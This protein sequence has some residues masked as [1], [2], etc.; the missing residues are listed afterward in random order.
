[1]SKIENYESQQLLKE[2][3]D[4]EY[5]FTDANGKSFPIPESGSL[6]LLAMGYQGLIAWRKE[7]S[8]SRHKG[9]GRQQTK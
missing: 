7:K 1:M 8:K 3:Y 9:L 2:L 5:N 4:Q 6:G